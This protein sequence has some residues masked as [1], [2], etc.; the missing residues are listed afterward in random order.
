[1]PAP[2]DVSART[3]RG[4][5]EREA[6][7]PRC[8]LALPLQPRFIPRRCHRRTPSEGLLHLSCCSA[9][10]GVLNASLA[11]AAFPAIARGAFQLSAVES[12]DLP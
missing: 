7:C 8:S 3:G 12:S 10:G 11:G 5:D 2:A 6:R 4:G 1:M 9:A